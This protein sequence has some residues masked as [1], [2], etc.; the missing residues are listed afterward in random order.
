MSIKDAIRIAE[1]KGYVFDASAC[2]PHERAL[3]DMAFWEALGRGLGVDW[4]ALWRRFF[5]YLKE[6]KTPAEFFA[7]LPED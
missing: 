4:L 5:D 6:R 1:S 2:H 7:A 3:L